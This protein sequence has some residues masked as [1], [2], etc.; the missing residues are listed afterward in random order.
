MDKI[1]AAAK[2]I[3]TARRSRAPLA[4][5]APRTFS[6]AI[7]NRRQVSLASSV[8][9]TIIGMLTLKNIPAMMQTMPTISETR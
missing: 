1:L 2:F 3:A 9:P 6:A 8:L 4:A 5:L 7:V